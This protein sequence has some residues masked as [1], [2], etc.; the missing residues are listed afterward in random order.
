VPGS[1]QVVPFSL[2]FLFQETLFSFFPRGFPMNIIR[3]FFFFC[4]GIPSLSLSLGFIGPSAGCGITLSSSS[5]LSHPLPPMAEGSFA[6]PFPGRLPSLRGF[7]S[8]MCFFFRGFSLLRPNPSRFSPP[9]TLIPRFFYG[10]LFSPF[11][12]LQQAKNN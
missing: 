7:P 1:F 9:A 5:L 3:R 12:G 11:L 10:T 4:F 2:C 8:R 6:L